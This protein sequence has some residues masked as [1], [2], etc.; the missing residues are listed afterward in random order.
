MCYSAEEGD[1]AGTSQSR[2][3]E[4]QGTKY[5][6]AHDDSLGLELNRAQPQ[7]LI[8]LYGGSSKGPVQYI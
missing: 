2:N 4:E 6:E 7:L 1:Y 3:Y 8:N 5:L